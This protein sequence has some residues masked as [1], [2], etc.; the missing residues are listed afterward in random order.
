MNHSVHRE[1]YHPLT[2]EF[3]YQC[4]AY[5][6]FV[7]AVGVGPNL[8]PTAALIHVAVSTHYKPEQKK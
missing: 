2:T 7:E 1:M 6:L 5:T 3:S 8:M 4:N